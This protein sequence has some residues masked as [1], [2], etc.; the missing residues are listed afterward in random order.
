MDTIRLHQDGE[1]YTILV[2]NHIV[3]RT[4]SKTV[5]E[6]YYNQMASDDWRGAR[7]ITPKPRTA[8]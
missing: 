4:T 2:N 3:L 8:N 7:L 6:Y 5:A 1:H